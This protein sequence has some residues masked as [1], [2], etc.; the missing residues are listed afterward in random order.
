MLIPAFFIVLPNGKQPKCPSTVECINPLWCISQQ[1]KWSNRCSD[2]HEWIMTRCWGKDASLK[3]GR[4]AGFGSRGAQS[5]LEVRTAVPLAAL[6]GEAGRA[7]KGLM[8]HWPCSSSSSGGRAMVVFTLWNIYCF[9][10]HAFCMCVYTCIFTSIIINFTNNNIL[11]KVFRVKGMTTRYP[12]WLMWLSIPF[13]M[14]VYGLVGHGKRKKET[15]IH[16]QTH[17]QWQPQTLPN[18]PWG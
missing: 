5:S 11:Q 7:A 1:W 3:Q 8:E 13:S 12:T 9:D 2:P 15:H 14:Q 18:V 10:W 6:V 17:P 4:R 16:T